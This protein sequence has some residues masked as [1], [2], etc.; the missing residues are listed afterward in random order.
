MLGGSGMFICTEGG[1]S[2]AA[3]M[4]STLFARTAPA[5]VLGVGVG[6]VGG[7]KSS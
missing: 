7:F 2:N 4:G 3:G 1:D 6:D 5:E